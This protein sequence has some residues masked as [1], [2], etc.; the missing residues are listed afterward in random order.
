MTTCPTKDVISGSSDA[1]FKQFYCTVH[2]GKSRFSASSNLFALTHHTEESASPQSYKSEGTNAQEEEGRSLRKHCHLS[3]NLQRCLG[4]KGPL[5]LS[6]PLNGQL[7]TCGHLR[8]SEKNSSH[9]SLAPE[10]FNITA[11][12]LAWD[13]HDRP[14]GTDIC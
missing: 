13:H 14:V 11:L 3:I 7:S 12:L 6:G 4:I 5:Q 9:F 2:V 8:E 10:H 1:S